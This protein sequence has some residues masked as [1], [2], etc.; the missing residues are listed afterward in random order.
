MLVRATAAGDEAAWRVLVTRHFTR[1]LPWLRGSAG[2]PL[3]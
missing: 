2:A 1:H 3:R